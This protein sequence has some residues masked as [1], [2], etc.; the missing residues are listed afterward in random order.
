MRLPG[1]L[2]PRVLRQALRAIFTRPFTTPFPA[3][4]FEPADAFRGRPR[5]DADGCMGCGACAQ[6]CPPKCI[7]VVDD[8]SVSP[9]LRRLVQH[10]DACI[11]CGQCARHCPTQRGIRMSH[12][13]DCAGFG[14][15]DFEERVEKP[16]ALCERCGAPVAP[17]DQL[18]WL[19]RDLGPAA[20]ANS[21]LTLVIARDLGLADP[22]VRGDGVQRADRLGVLC[23]RCRRRAALAS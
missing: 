12:E 19:A 6:V 1:F 18:R 13:Y 2:Q 20:Y 5:F 22:A 23:P 17:V 15:A 3:G 7:E 11:W 16:L 8:L 21:T 9:P 4:S 14:P 10:L